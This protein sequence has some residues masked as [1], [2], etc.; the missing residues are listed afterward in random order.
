MRTK[1]EILTDTEFRNEGEAE[2]VLVEVLIDIRD[3]FELLND[4]F[5]DVI[6]RPNGNSHGAIRVREI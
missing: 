6:K 4:A 3:Q 5:S 2:R 1:K